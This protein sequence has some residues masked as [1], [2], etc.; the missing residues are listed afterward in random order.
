MW[1]KT[2]GK[3]TLLKILDFLGNDGHTIY[4]RE[5]IEELGVPQDI[6]ATVCI[7]HTYNKRNPKSVILA[8]DG[9]KEDL[10]GVYGLDL[11]KKISADMGIFTARMGRGWQ[12]RD[13]QTLVRTEID[14]W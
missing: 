10:V 1:T 3:E 12:M 5:K 14:T 2:L 4:S 6:L 11:L 9:I 7:K 8:A 13:L